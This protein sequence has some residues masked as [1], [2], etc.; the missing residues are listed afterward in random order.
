MSDMLVDLG[1]FGDYLGSDVN[2]TM[3]LAMVLMV[4]MVVMR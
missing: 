1:G 2:V 3:M 4:A